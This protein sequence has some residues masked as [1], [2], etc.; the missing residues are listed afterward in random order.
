MSVCGPAAIISPA[1][2]SSLDPTGV[3][4]PTPPPP[5][6]G[7]REI[8]SLACWTVSSSKPGCAVA[9]LRAPTTSLFWQS[10]GPQP[11][12][13]N[14]HFFKM[15]SISAMRIYLDFELDESYTPTLIHFAAGTGYH[16]LQEFSV[17][18][19][20]QPQGWI[21]VDWDAVGDDA[22]ADEGGEPPLLRCM[23]IQV[24]ICENHQ[25]GKDTHLRGLQIFAKDPAAEQVVQKGTNGPETQ[26][27]PQQTPRTLETVRRPKHSWDLGDWEAPVLR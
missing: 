1:N 3:L 21:D 9:A 22:D 24:R 15:V 14:I 23:L 27:Q 5:P 4:S 17:M 20:N 13:L 6:F 8:S 19:F 16:D 11:H 25:N 10:D 7:L 12:L 26:Q 18:R 2:T